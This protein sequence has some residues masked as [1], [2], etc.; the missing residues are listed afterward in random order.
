MLRGQVGARL[1]AFSIGKK[2]SFKE[3]IGKHIIQ[4]TDYRNDYVQENDGDYIS[5]F[6]SEFYKSLKI[7]CPDC[8]EFVDKCTAV[9]FHGSGNYRNVKEGIKECILLGIFYNQISVVKCLLTILKSHY[10]DIDLNFTI[11]NSQFFPPY[12]TPLFQACLVN[13][14]RLV[15]LFLKLRHS[16]PKIHRLDC[17]C[18]N[19]TYE[20]YPALINV[21]RLDFYRAIS[22]DAFLWYG[23]NDPL[24]SALKLL[25]ELDKTSSLD[26]A[27][28]V[29][30]QNLAINVRKFI[31][32]LFTATKTP[33]EAKNLLSSINGCE[34]S[35][36]KSVFPII[37]TYFEANV[38][39]IFSDPNVVNV[40]QKKFI[41]SRTLFTRMANPRA[42]VIIDNFIYILMLILFEV[43]FRGTAFNNEKY[44]RIP[45]G[46]FDIGIP[47]LFYLYGLGL[48]V[49]I[50]Y[51]CWRLGFKVAMIKW[52]TWFDFIISQF[53]II[54]AYHYCATVGELTNDGIYEINRRHW[55][56]FGVSIICELTFAIGCII[57][58]WRLFYI[59]MKF[60]CIGLIVISVAKCA[61]VIIQYSF[62]AF[63]I[64]ISFN[65][66][67]QLIFRPYSYNKSFKNGNINEGEI[68][69]MSYYEDVW[70]TQ[71]M[72][73]WSIYGY[74]APWEM[75]IVVGEAGPSTIDPP[76]VEHKLTQNVGECV[77]AVFYVRTAE[78]AIIEAAD[79]FKY[80]D[81]IIKFDAFYLGTAVPP[82]Y[83]ILYFIVSFISWILITVKYHNN[84]NL[85]DGIYDPEIYKFRYKVAEQEYIKL[86]N[87]SSDEENELIEGDNDLNSKE[88]SLHQ[89][90]NEL[91]PKVFK[92]FTNLKKIY[93]KSRFL[94]KPY[95]NIPL[96]NDNPD[97]E[98]EE[99]LGRHL[100]YVFTLK[101]LYQR[102]IFSSGDIKFSSFIY[103]NKPLYYMFKEKKD[104]K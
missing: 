88:K 16:L 64:I 14:Y 9:F 10:P 24:L 37:G 19:C 76:T 56:P 22:S 23:T 35:Y 53:Y 78:Q 38:K 51:K 77:I 40:L 31:K 93:L 20:I 29:T 101:A 83:N 34:L 18:S 46:R 84:S 65:A 44:S 11:E 91:T 1:I 99:Y 79:E 67:I 36:I 6:A 95:F 43:N 50:I 5:P 89:I 25:K 103:K 45:S 80:E 104:L 3:E 33:E 57:L 94:D 17:T 26:P 66:G 7:L 60:K 21:L 71:K 12:I 72:L 47:F 82:P 61:K 98:I 73:Y 4:S 74:L 96:D 55:D 59:L 15:E 62:I 42:Y 97:K 8:E 92:M 75:S 54:S 81:S 90:R 28:E 70:T 30:Y 68:S 87:S 58:I 48:F 102:I 39:D 13:N 85:F 69:Q 27:N 32:K 86:E 2:T 100:L 41:D 63:I 52:W 49:R